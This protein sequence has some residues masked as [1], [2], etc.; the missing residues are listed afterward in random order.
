VLLKCQWQQLLAAQTQAPLPRPSQS[1]LALVA[2]SF[3]LTGRQALLFQQSERTADVW[4]STG[5]S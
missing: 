1:E 2:A 5:R 3:G 4:R